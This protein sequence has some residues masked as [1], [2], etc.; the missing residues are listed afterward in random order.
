M[1]RTERATLLPLILGLLCAPLPAWPQATSGEA[2]FVKNN[3]NL[4]LRCTTGDTVEGWSEWKT[5]DPG[6]EIHRF[7]TEE[8]RQTYLAC[9]PPV[10]QRTFRLK[11]GERYTFLRRNGSNEVTVRRIAASDE[12]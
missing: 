7:T 4:R 12:E 5:V 8:G 11:A 2:F 3:T 6:K 9:T 10:E 1:R